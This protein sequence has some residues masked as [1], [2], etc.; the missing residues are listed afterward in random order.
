MMGLL[1]KA[2]AGRKLR[3]PAVSAVAIL[4]EAQKKNY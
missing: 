4:E 2:S 3:D 1:D